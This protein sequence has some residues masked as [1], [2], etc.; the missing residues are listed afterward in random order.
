MLNIFSAV[1]SVT[2]FLL[3]PFEALKAEEKE[4]LN[5]RVNHLHKIAETTVR[6]IDPLIIS[7]SFFLSLVKDIATYEYLY[8]TGQYDHLR[9]SSYN[10]VNSK[11][12]I[13]W[14][15]NLIIDGKA[16]QNAFAEYNTEREKQGRD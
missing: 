12:L 7:F 4:A 16:I 3:I 14:L 15:E 2:I 1:G 9:V 8:K 5:T 6:I 11:R 13:S 10:S